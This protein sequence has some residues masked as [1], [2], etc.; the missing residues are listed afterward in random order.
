M[1]RINMKGIYYE[2]RPTIITLKNIQAS[3]EMLQTRVQDPVGS[4]PLA[5]GGGG[6]G[7]ERREE[8]C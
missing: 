1:I 2:V 7:R 3:L 5:R 6:E 8:I 4:Q